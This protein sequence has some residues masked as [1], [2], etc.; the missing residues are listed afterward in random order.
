MPLAPQLDTVGVIARHVEDLALMLGLLAGPDARD[1]SAS[2]LPVPDFVRRLDDPIQGLKVG[3]DEKVIAEAHPDVQRMVEDVVTVLTRLG[4]SQAPCAF[5]D[6]QT[7]DHLV[8]L[9]QLPDASA[10]HRNYLSTRA[11]EYGPQVRA[12]LE[13]GHFVPA[14]D[15]LT[16]LRARGT[17]LQRTLDRTFQGIDLAILPVLADP[18]PTI[19]ELDVGGGPK[20]QAAMGRVVKFTR[21]I[22][23]LGLPTLTIPVPRGTGLPNGIQLVGRPFAEAQLF[24]IGQA[25]QR[26]VPPEIARPLK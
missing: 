23:Y 9:V 14:V 15:H 12:R 8:Q 10:A 6:W 11:G 26:E 22:N 4:V 2:H 3:V 18:L 21:P 1:P 24:A 17:Y 19:A 7:L 25:F 16:A 13:V 20:V 5:P